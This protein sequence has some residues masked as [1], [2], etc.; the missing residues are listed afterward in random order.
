M[1]TFIIR[2]LIAS[3]FVLLAATYIMYVLTALAGD[4]Q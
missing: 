3:F 4:P 1:A 2:R